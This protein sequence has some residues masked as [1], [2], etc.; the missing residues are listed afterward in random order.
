MDFGFS[1]QEEKFRQEVRDFLNKEIPPAWVKSGTT[2][3]GEIDSEEEWAFW[4]SIQRKLGEKGWLAISWPKE[5]G[6]LGRSHMEQAIFMEEMT[7]RGAPGLAPGNHNHVGPIL[8]AWGTEEQKKT[9]L[10]PMA[11]GETIWSP[12]WSEPNAGSDLANISATAVQDGDNYIINGQK[13]WSV[14]SFLADWTLFLART[15]PDSTGH[16]GLS[17]FLADLKTPG[18]TITPVVDTGGYRYWG[19]ITLDNVPVPRE[20]MIG[21]KN[22]G[23]TVMTASLNNER[24]AFEMLGTA[25]RNLD[26]VVHYARE[27]KRNGE[28]LVNNP[29][30]RH[31]LAQLAIEVEVTRLVYYRVVWG[32][33][34]GITL[35][36]EASLA[37]VFGDETV[38]RIVTAGM[39]IMGLHGQL[40]PGSKWASF[41]AKMQHAY[42]VNPAWVIGGGS[43]EIQKSLIAWMG[44]KMPR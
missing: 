27:T 32:R 26:L 19:E 29:V 31:K 9:H 12:A 43:S 28:P 22:E 44:L 36:H 4:K 23:W 24:N 37:K 25:R 38:K 17:V 10:S 33:D 2:T 34:Q 30:I 14:H 35:I 21:P 13:R 7:Y 3:P 20:N 42:L 39:E 6:G 5:Y 1:K 16:R 11:R 41:A 40:R 18:I 8:L 15:A